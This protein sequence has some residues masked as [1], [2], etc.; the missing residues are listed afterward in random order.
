MGIYDRTYYRDD[1]S[2]SLLN[3]RSMVF[4]LIIVNV[5]VFFL[6]S[7]LNEWPVEYLELNSDLLQRPWECWRLVTYGFVHQ[8]LPDSLEHARLV[9][10]RPCR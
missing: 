2:G 7:L 8:S 3:G 9:L 6:N 10:L 4:W 5:V 1:E